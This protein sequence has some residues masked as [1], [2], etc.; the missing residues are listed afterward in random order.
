M[1][2]CIYAAV[3]I[4]AVVIGSRKDETPAVKK[5]RSQIE[6]LQAIHEKTLEELDDIHVVQKSELDSGL[7]NDDPAIARAAVR[8]WAAK[9]KSALPEMRRLSVAASSPAVRKRAKDVIGQ[10]TG[11]WGSQVDLVWKR[12]MKEAMHQGKPI[13]LLHLFGKLDE[14]FC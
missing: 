9:G 1:R 11:N 12:S 14:E 13:L 5:L 8:A 7:G 3:G 6:N 4:S 2:F 10:I